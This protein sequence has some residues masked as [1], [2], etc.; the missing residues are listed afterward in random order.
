M[1]HRNE[2]L[3]RRQVVLSCE[4]R[5]NKKKKPVRMPASFPLI[6]L[7]YNKLLIGITKNNAK[8]CRK[9]RKI[10]NPAGFTWRGGPFKL[11]VGLILYN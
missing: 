9:A 4:N 8:L 6:N 10:K 3:I 11:V 7:N 1:L 5:G 2:C